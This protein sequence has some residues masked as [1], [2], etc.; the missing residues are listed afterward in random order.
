[1]NITN[2]DAAGR[3]LGMQPKTQQQRGVKIV[4]FEE[5]LRIN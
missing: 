3:T 4:I 5:T 1:V 2:M